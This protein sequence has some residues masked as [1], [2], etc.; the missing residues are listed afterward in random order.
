[1]RIEEIPHH[2]KELIERQVQSLAKHD[3]DGLLK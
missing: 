2:R 1:V 3:S